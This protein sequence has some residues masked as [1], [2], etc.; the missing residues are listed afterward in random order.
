M[1]DSVD[2]IDY[3]DSSN[4]EFNVDIYDKKTPVHYGAVHIGTGKTSSNMIT[5]DSLS[6]NNVSAMKV[7][8]EGAE[9]LVFYGAK[10]TIKKYKPVIVFEYNESKLS[11]DIIKTMNLDNDISTFNIVEYC[12]SLGYKDM[13]ELYIDDYMLVPPGRNQVIKNTI[14][15]F[16][17][18]N[19]FKRF[20]KNQLNGYN[21]YKFIKPRW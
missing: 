8:V 3:L 16:K 2:I 10:N 12:K 20:N 5:I 13:Y 1:S 6:L 21:L 19:K 9:P 4:N 11:K 18:T 15:K 14:A 17:P 7:D